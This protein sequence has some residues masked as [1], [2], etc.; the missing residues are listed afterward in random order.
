MR[1]NRIAVVPASALLA[2][3]ALTA[4][5]SDDKASDVANSATGAAKSAGSSATDGAASAGSSA[6]DGAS[7][8]A[9]SATGSQS[10]SGSNSSDASD[11]SSSCPTDDNTKAFAKTR[12]VAD[13]GLAA[14]SFKHWIY[15]PYK[16]GSFDKNRKGGIDKTDS[17]K[18]AA[19]AVAD[20]KLLSNALDNAKANPTLCKTVA[21]PISEAMGKLKNVDKSQ[22]AKGV[23]TGNVGSLATAAGAF[24]SI[25]QAVKGSNDSGNKVTESQDFSKSDAFDGSAKKLLGN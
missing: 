5:G 1:M 12:F 3:S 21:K 18:A 19:V 15:N 17:L 24:G 8:A 13:L 11:A 9:G 6:T 22:I 16:K 20:Y 23:L 25:E 14:G 2:V 10:A 4:C 7:S